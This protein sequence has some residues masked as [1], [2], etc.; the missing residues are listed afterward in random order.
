MLG[1]GLGTLP[2]LV[3][4]SRAAFLVAAAVRSPKV[5]ATAAFVMAC[6]GVLQVSDAVRAAAWHGSVECCVK[7]VARSPRQM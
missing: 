4:M 2:M 6:F 5:R 1:F 3:A 7:S